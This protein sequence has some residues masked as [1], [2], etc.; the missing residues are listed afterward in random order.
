MV[1]IEA[2]STT[3]DDVTE[4]RDQHHFDVAKLEGYLQA[5]KLSGFKAPLTVKQFGHGQSNPT[6]LLQSATGQQ[7]VLRKQPPG[8]L[9]SK[10]AH[11][12][13]R[14]FEIIS[15]LNKTDVP[16]PQAYLLC[17]DNS[18]VG[19]MF[20]I[21]EFKQGRVFKDVTL[22]GVPMAERRELWKAL[23]ETLAQIHNVD[24]A[25]V[26]LENFG[27]AGGY[28]TRQVKSLSKVS[29]AQLGAAPDK[30]PAIPHFDAIAGILRDQQPTDAVSICHG[31]F[32]MDN[33]IYHPTEPRVIAV[34]DWEMS[35]IGHY[36]ADIAN[37]LS[38]FYLSSTSDSAVSPELGEMM[39]AITPAAAKEQGLPSQEELVTMYSGMRSPELDAAQE[40]RNVWYY[41]TFYWWKSAV[42]FQGI[43][44]RF[45]TGQASSSYAQTVG[46]FTP[47]MGEVAWRGA[48]NVMKGASAKL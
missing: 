41:L 18:I 2:M 40:Q 35:T 8:P 3:S 20:Y 29:I 23:L 22:P 11:R 44:A 27:R 17:T 45:A 9:I 4:V 12:V 15:A 43:A 28:F 24:Y 5:R 47:A 37:C 31:D 36:G 14:E 6:F 33:V 13:D 16:V 38:S 7:Y 19:N 26:G 32:K 46:N 30:V 39:K 25:A 10:T 42:I 1:D 34:I 48:Q 21:M